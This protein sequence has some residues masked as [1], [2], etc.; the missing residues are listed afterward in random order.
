MAQLATLVDRT[1][2][3]PLDTGDPERPL[4]QSLMFTGIAQG[5]YA[6]QLWPMLTTGISQ[7]TSGDGTGLL[8]LADAYLER[9][10]DGHYG[11]TLAANPAIFC[12]DVP[13]TRTPEQIAEGAAALNKQFPRSA[14][15]SAGAASAA[16][17]GPTRP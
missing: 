4:T 5:L 16:R 15:P 17:S 1:D 11:Q 12:L 14:A 9:T 13:E 10:E 7:A 6:Q 3:N 8:T 2:E